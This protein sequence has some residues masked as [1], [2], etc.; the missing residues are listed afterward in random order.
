MSALF[1]SNAEATD[2]RIAG[3]DQAQIAT[4]R[5]TIINPGGS[6]NTYKI[7]K[8]ASVS[9]E[10]NADQIAADAL[11]RVSQ[12]SAGFSQSLTALQADAQSR[13]AAILGKLT[14]LAESQQTGGEPKRNNTILF[15]V[16]GLAAAWAWTQRS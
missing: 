12:L 10:S 1:G 9:F 11:S 3:T 2:R 8:G 7:G 4:Q 5:G 16:L 13:D 14:S 15:I 6:V